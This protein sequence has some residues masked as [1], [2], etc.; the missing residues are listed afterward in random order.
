[1]DYLE[2][3]Q[4]EEEDLR[5]SDNEEEEEEKLPELP[6]EPELPQPDDS[7]FEADSDVDTN[8]SPLPKE[9][10]NPVPPQTF[11]ENLEYQ[12]DEDVETIIESKRERIQNQRGL[13][14]LI[15]TQTENELIKVPEIL[16]LILKNQETSKL[17]FSKSILA[18]IPK[19]PHNSIFFK[20]PRNKIFSKDFQSKSHFLYTRKIKNSIEAKF[21]KSK[22]K[23]NDQF[24]YL[25]NGP[26]TIERYSILPLAKYHRGS[27]N[28]FEFKKIFQ[29]KIFWLKFLQRLT[30]I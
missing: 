25:K 29:G 24:L 9:Q 10:Q 12:L 6:T 23:E 17:Q 14:R 5:K 8:S 1:M 21:Q 18:Y 19:K 20:P 22:F 28:S 7:A 3:S 2:K 11:Q 27:R 16:P 13:K 15:F 26:Q 4:K 30:K